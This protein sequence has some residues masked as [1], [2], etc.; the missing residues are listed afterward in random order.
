MDFG[1]NNIRCLTSSTENGLNKET[2]N[3]AHWEKKRLKLAC[4]RLEWRV[5]VFLIKL[6]CRM[7]Q[8]IR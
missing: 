2:D 7:R 3:I 4:E 1:D 6:V 5:L 8:R